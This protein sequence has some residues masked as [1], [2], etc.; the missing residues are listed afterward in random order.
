M[1]EIRK[2]EGR[3]GPYYMTNI[4]GCVYASSDIKDIKAKLSGLEVKEHR[5]SDTW[6]WVDRVRVSEPVEEDRHQEKMDRRQES[7]SVKDRIK[8][9]A[10]ELHG[11]AEQL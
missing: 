6:A 2:M 10:E 5:L 9:L 4:G 11:L 7:G 1:S 3:K 8:S